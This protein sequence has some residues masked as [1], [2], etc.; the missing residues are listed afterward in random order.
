MIVEAVTAAWCVYSPPT[1]VPRPLALV[2]L[3]LVA[4]VWRSTLAV[5]MPLHERL[6]REGCRPDLVARLVA[7][8]WPRTV[9]W[10]ARAV[11]AA[12]MINVAVGP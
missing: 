11:V 10:T 6:G 1:G 12:W 3:G 4:A 7:S 2:G 5:Q 9:L 8:N